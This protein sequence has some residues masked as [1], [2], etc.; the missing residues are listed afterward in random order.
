MKVDIMADL[1]FSVEEIPLR[2][3]GPAT[4]NIAE[5]RQRCP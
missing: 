3:V 1:V 5:V 2:A 4:D